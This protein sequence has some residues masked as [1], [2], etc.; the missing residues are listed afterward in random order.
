[1]EANYKILHIGLEE[2]GE[3]RNIIKIFLNLK[4]IKIYHKRPIISEKRTK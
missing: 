4:I 1:M 2:L 3:G